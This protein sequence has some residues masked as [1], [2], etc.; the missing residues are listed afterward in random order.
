MA[1]VG[2]RIVGVGD[3]VGLGNGVGVVS[4]AIWRGVP[5]G[6][7]VGVTVSVGSWAGA[8]GL[9]VIP[10]AGKAGSAAVCKVSVAAGISAAEMR[11]GELPSGGR[12]RTV[13]RT[14]P[15]R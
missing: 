5:V 12:V 8:A 1:G 2:R 4:K 14:Q 7:A 10:D 15:V 9:C 13:T 3:G 6:E 11:A